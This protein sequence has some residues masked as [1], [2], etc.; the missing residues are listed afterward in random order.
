[1]APELAS[2]DPLPTLDEMAQAGRMNAAEIAEFDRET[3]G[4]LGAAFPELMVVANTFA[5][6]LRLVISDNPEAEY[7][8]QLLVTALAVDA[9]LEL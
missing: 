9:G 3:L 5:E 7:G 8:C 1:M 6:M 4:R 2:F